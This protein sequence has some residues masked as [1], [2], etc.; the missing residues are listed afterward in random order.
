MVSISKAHRPRTPVKRLSWL[1]NIFSRPR[2]QPRTTSQFIQAV[3]STDRAGEVSVAIQNEDLAEDV[4]V[5]T[6]LD[7]LPFCCHADLILM[8]RE[9]LL[10][11]ASALNERLP[12][13]LRIDTVRSDSYI[14]N[15]IEFIVGLKNAPPDA[16]AKPTTPS[17]KFVPSSPISPLAHHGH[18]QNSPLVAGPSSLGDVTEE[19][20]PDSDPVI[21]TPRQ[22]YR[23]PPLKRRKLIQGP[24]SPTPSHVQSHPSALQSLGSTL[25]ARRIARSRSTHVPGPLRPPSDRVFRSRSQTM[26]PQH[27]PT[28]TPHPSLASFHTPKR[29]R[30]P[31]VQLSSGTISTSPCLSEES[32]SSPTPRIARRKCP[33]GSSVERETDMITGLQKMSVLFVGSDN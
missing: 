33:R 4:I 20:E 27:L 29:I 24:I 1:S 7:K 31:R 3:R 26:D 5:L 21:A 22:R 11:A 17:R 10:T 23:R 14:R 2:N 25:T 19:E 18:S 15:S 28:V 9:Q 12:A 32:P 30:T 13:A 16:P 6:S 8:K